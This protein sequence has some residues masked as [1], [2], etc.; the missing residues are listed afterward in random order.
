MNNRQPVDVIHRV[1][2]ASVLLMAAWS[3]VPSAQDRRLLDAN[4]Y[5]RDDAYARPL[6]PAADQK[7]QKIDGFK[8]KDTLKEVVAISLKSRDDGNKYWGRIAGSKYE[9]L[10][11]DWVEAKFRKYNLQ[12]THRQ[13]FK[14]PTQWFPTD[15]NYT[16]TAAGKSYTFRSVNPSLNSPATPPAGL[17]LDV[18]WVGTGTAADF[19]GRD[20][21]GK[22]VL[23]HSIPAPGSMGHTA[24]FEGGMARAFKNGA[25][26]VGVV[27]GI[28][29]N[30]A[31]WQALGNAGDAGVGPRGPITIP[32]FY[33]G[34]NDGKV[35]RDLIGAGQQVKLKMRLTVE[36]R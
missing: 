12:D 16:F 4:G 15:W 11:H 35:I 17:E 24:Q 5:V 21:R 19:A 26:A 7:Y 33:M 18:V 34:Y 32:G 30:F 3:S 10:M 14:L 23:I 8:M 9:G 22:A 20:V 27:Y 1:L 13:P 6:L 25:A 28:S 31:I 29:D 36:H 2:T